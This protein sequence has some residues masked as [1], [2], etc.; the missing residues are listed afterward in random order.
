MYNNLHVS[1]F[2]PAPLGNNPNVLATKPYDLQIYRNS[3][4]QAYNL[5]YQKLWQLSYIYTQDGS[6]PFAGASYRVKYFK[7]MS[8]KEIKIPQKFKRRIITLIS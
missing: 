7:A 5:C 3:Y 4:T 1:G 2:E 8:K 6:A